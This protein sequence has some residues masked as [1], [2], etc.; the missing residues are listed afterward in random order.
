M[1]NPRDRRLLEL[2]A[3]EHTAGLPEARLASRTGTFDPVEPACVEAPSTSD[4]RIGDGK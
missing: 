4:V 2:S 3:D 1:D